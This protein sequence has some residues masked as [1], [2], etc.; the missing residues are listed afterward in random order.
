[1][2]QPRPH[3][4]LKCEPWLCQGDIFGNIRVLDYPDIAGPDLVPQLRVG[5]AMLVTHDCSLDKMTG[6]GRH[7]IE[8]LAFVRIREVDALPPDR[9]EL[10]RSSH[11]KVQ[12]YEAQYL[13]VLPDIGESYVLVSD[14]YFLPARYF[15]P[16]IEIYADQPEPNGHLTIAKNDSRRFRL[17]DSELEIFRIKWNA[18]WTR[19]MPRQS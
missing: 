12:P 15:D 6:K 5:Q 8:R 7:T 3:S 18:Q 16:R 17:S 19:T 10:L 2:T 14:P 13:G 4:C 9:A 1:M 11:G